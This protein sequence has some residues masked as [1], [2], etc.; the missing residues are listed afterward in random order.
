MR[1]N[2]DEIE[3]STWVADRGVGINDKITVLVEFTAPQ[4]PGIYF[5]CYRLVQGNNNRFGDKVFLNLT[6]KDKAAEKKETLLVAEAEPEQIM[7]KPE[8]T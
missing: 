2:G 7:A 3:S 4:K 5:A 1:A 8:K 6:V